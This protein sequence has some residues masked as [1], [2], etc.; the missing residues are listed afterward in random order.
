MI[1]EVDIDKIGAELIYQIQDHIHDA[2]ML[3]GC[4]DKYQQVIYSLKDE[5]YCDD[6]AWSTFRSIAEHLKTKE[7]N[8]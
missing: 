5:T 7:V 4:L 2:M 3:A 6:A 8:K 1:I